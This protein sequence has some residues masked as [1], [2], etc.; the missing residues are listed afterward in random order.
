MILKSL[1]VKNF[2]NIEE[3]QSDF[4]ENFNIFFGKN[5]QGK[6]NFIESIY[7]SGMSKSFKTRNFNDII[8]N[9]DKKNSI[10]TSGIFYY[11]KTVKK[12]EN[13]IDN[14]SRELMVNSLATDFSELLNY[15]SFI[16]F[17]PDD[18]R[19]IKGEPGYRRKFLNETASFIYPGYYP[20]LL[21]YSKIL[22]N[23]NMLLKKRQNYRIWDEMFIET[24][25]YILDKRK[26][27]IEEFCKEFSRIY[28]VI[29]D[30][31]TELK[32][33]YRGHDNIDQKIVD[34]N[35]LKD[36]SLGYV[37]FG[38]HRDDLIIKMDNFNVKNTASQGQI[39]TLVL[40]MKIAQTLTI[41]KI[42]KDK[43]VIILD[44]VL[45]ELDINRQRNLINLLKDKGQIFITA[46]DINKNIIE[47]MENYKI[48][49]IREGKIERK[50]QILKAG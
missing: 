14:S 11:N 25:N 5:G 35:R 41:E 10:Y 24:A 2:R 32:I 12:I 15:N 7:F 31:D 17:L 28:S 3:E 40:T 19:I 26:K 9:Q 33:D 39:R 4:S 1:F 50:Q 46:N 20:A 8:M 18:L 6:T 36:E 27:V 23:R 37:S 38:P 21:K 48:F 13:K 42:K 44:D 45:S 16:T 47:L 34:K 29:A 43:P 30:N 49:H 22:L